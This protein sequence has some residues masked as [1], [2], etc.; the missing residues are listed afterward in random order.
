[1]YIHTY[2]IYIYIYIYL[3]RKPLPC[4]PEAE[5][6]ILPLIWCSASLSPYRCVASSGSTSTVV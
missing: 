2:N 5:T 6:P 1:M 4:S 3:L